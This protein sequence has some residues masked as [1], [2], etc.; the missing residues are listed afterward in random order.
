M[1]AGLLVG[2]DA[3]DVASFVAVAAGRG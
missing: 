3:Q 2:T 1:P